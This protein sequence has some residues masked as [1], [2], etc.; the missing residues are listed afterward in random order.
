MSTTTTTPF[1]NADWFVEQSFTNTKQL[2][3]II[4]HLTKNESTFVKRTTL[5]SEIYLKLLSTL[6]KETVWNTKL[7]NILFKWICC[8]IKVY[9]LKVVLRSS[10]FIEALF[11]LYIP[12]KYI[13]PLKRIKGFP[14]QK[15]QF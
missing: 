1:F 10:G 3:S 2:E 7:D 14:I 6:A 15:M 13:Q 4:R 11:S 9:K 8:G 12:S 5:L